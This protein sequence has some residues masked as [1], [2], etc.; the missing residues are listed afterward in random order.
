MQFVQCLWLDVC[1]GKRLFS[2]LK[3][4]KPVAM[5]T[6]VCHVIKL[7]TSFQK[8]LIGGCYNKGIRVFKKGHNL[9]PWPQ[10]LQKSLALDRV[11]L[12]T[13]D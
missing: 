13:H 4:L 1:V 12:E 7:C 6:R 9:P 8:N 11:K 10:E 2:H 5:I 3:T